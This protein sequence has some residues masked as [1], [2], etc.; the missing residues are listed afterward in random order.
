LEVALEQFLNIPDESLARE[1]SCW[2]RSS[3]GDIADNVRAASPNA[4]NKIA[5]KQTVEVRRRVV[6]RSNMNRPGAI[7][8]TTQ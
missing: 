7:R 5:V 3:S 8:N 6:A 1:N 2:R 4:V